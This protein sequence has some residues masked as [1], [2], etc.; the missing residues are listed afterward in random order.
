MKYDASKLMNK[1]QYHPYLWQ[2]TRDLTD[3]VLEALLDARPTTHTT[4]DSNINTPVTNV[5]VFP[6]HRKCTLRY[7]LNP[8]I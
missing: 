5:T 1:E 7:I 4:E 2:R 3:D 6:L 8:Y